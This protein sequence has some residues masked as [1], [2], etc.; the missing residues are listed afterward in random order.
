[1]ALCDEMN[2]R[3]FYSICR[4]QGKQAKLR[5]VLETGRWVGLLAASPFKRPFDSLSSLVIKRNG[6]NLSRY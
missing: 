4:R 5:L 6:A 1:M 3:G 2:F